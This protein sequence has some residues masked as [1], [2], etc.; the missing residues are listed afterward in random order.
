MATET[1]KEHHDSELHVR[2]DAKVPYVRP[3]T[4]S[5]RKPVSASAG[6]GQIVAVVAKNR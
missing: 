6:S 1:K 4:L 3:R 2:G 5:V